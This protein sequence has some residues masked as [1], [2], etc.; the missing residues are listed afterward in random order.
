MTGG[1]IDRHEAIAGTRN[2]AST[3]H[4][5][6]RW[7][8]V[9][10]APTVLGVLWQFP[11]DIM[12]EHAFQMQ[13]APSTGLSWSLH[14]RRGARLSGDMLLACSRILASLAKCR[15]LGHTGLECSADELPE[16]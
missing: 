14:N 2:V 11:T 16:G 5:G 7:R 6:A 8:E 15:R 9:T 4:S 1:P 12:C 10:I 3:M 13:N